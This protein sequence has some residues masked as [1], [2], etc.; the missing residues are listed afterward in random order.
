MIT[1]EQAKQLCVEAHKG[2][3]RRYRPATAEEYT[4]DEVIAYPNDTFYFPNGNIMKY[5]PQNIE[6]PYTIK[7]PYHTHPFAVADMMTTDEE[8]IVA[9]LHDV[10]EDTEAILLNDFSMTE[11]YILFKNNKYSISSEIHYALSCLTKY[12]ENTYGEYIMDIKENKLATK[13]KIADIT[14]NLFDN[15]SEKAKAKYFKALPILLNTL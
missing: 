11:F 5:D 14:S 15:P 9:Y 2:Q 10:V 4:S 1:V 3:Y 13:V 12:S 7:E 8:K 6:C